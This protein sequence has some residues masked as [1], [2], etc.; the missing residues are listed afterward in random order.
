M[1]YYDQFLWKILIVVFFSSYAS[2]IFGI[3]IFE[4]AIFLNT[5][6]KLKIGT[7]T[8]WVLNKQRKLLSGYLHISRQLFLSKESSTTNFDKKSYESYRLQR[9]WWQRYAGLFKMVTVFWCGDLFR[10][11]GEFSNVKNRWPTSQ[12]SHQHPSPISMKPYR[13]MNY[14][15]T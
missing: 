2:A 6:N 14:D 12:S 3:A 1:F 13:V 8:Q 5:K 4:E 11:L 15:F 7:G 9:C 10:H